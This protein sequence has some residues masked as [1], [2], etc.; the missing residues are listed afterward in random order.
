MINRILRKTIVRISETVV[1]LCLLLPAMSLQAMA[2]SKIS[3]SGTVTSQIEDEPLAGASVRIKGTSLGVTTDVDGKYEILAEK[4]QVLQFSYIGYKSKEVTID[5]NVINVALDEDRTLLDDVVVVGY[6]TMKRSDITGSVVSVG[7]DEIKKTIVTSVDQALQGRAAGVQVTQNS[8]S[9]GGGISVAIRGVNSLNGNEPLYVIDGVAV[10]GK[11]SDGKTSALST[12][13]PSDIMSIEVLKDASA[14]AIYGSRAS[15]GVVLITTRHGQAGKTRVTYEG[16]YALQQIPK[17]LKTMNLRQYAQLYNERVEV[18]GWGEREEF[19]DPSVLGD[20]TDWQKEIFGNA[21][22]WNHQVSVSGGTE[23]TQFLVSGSYTDQK[24]I[25]VGSGFERFTARINV[26]TKITKWLQIGAQSSLSHTKRNNTID[27]NGVIQTA[28]RQLPEV[29]ARNPD[30]SWGY[31]ENNQLGIYY[32]NPLADALTRTNYNKGLQAMVNAYANVTLLPGLTARVEYGGTFDYG[33]WYFFQPEM[34]IGQFT[35]NSN[36][37][38]QSSNSRYTS[39]KQYITYMR[40]FGK[41]G[42][43]IMAGHESQE[44]KWENLSASRQ[45]YLFNNVTSINVGDLKTAS[46]GSGSGCFAIESYYGRLNYNFDNRSLVSL[47]IC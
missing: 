10:D 13:N 47:K 20:G 46:N 14:T 18:L 42:I 15:N 4:G 35:Q 11:S 3:V 31:Q 16:Y 22:M 7:A 8:G 27:D 5:R 34:T 44:S 36:S 6:G 43:N 21:G 26:D 33:N 41:H 38:R 1:M 40:D 28:L 23:S 19:A 37:Q 25:A 45:G 24:G 32:T 29:P 2:A 9:P 39:F 12:I 30:G 17:R